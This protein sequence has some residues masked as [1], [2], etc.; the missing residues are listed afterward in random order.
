VEDRPS[1]FPVEL[2]PGVVHSPRRRHRAFTAPSGILLF[3]CLFLPA[4]RVC[5]SP[6]YP[7]ELWPLATPYA[8][9]AL[10]AVMALLGRPNEPHP[11]VVVIRGLMWATVIGWGVYL[12]GLAASEGEWL[13]ALVWAPVGTVI[14][15]LYG[16]GRDEPAAARVTIATAVVSAVWFG[17][18]CFDPG[19]LAGIYIAAATAVIMLIGGLEWRREIQRDRAPRIPDAR[20]R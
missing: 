15:F 18:F 17:L 6:A 9:G 13:P 2:E 8:L 16:R 12:I 7:Y 11:L 3:V 10:V 20:L 1:S 5:G 4:Y 14:L 19:A